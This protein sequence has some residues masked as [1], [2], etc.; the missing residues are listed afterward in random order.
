MRNGWIWIV[1]AAT[2]GVPALAIASEEPF[3][4]PLG[5]LGPDYCLSHAFG[6]SG[7][8]ET[9][10]GFSSICNQYKYHAFQWTAD[11]G[12]DPLG[13]ITGDLNSGA[14]AASLDGSV[15]VGEG[16]IPDGVE[17]FLWTAQDGMVGLGEL[18]GGEHYSTAWGVS[19]D[20]SVVVGQSAVA[21]GA[22]AFRWTPHEGMVALEMPDGVWAS[23]A[24]GVSADGLVIVGDM[25]N[26]DYSGE[27]FRWTE[28]EGMVGLGDLAGGSF[29]SRASAC[30]ADGW[31]VAGWGQSD[32]GWEAFRWTPDEGMV[33]LGFL[34][35][36]YSRAYA[37]S[38][39]GSVV[40]GEAIVED[41]DHAPFIWTPQ[42]GMRD[43]QEVLQSDLG[44]DLGDLVNLV[45]ANGI[46]AD[47]RTIVGWGFNRDG[48]SEGWVAYLGAS[49]RADFNGDGTVDSR[50]VVAYMNTWAQKSPLA[51]WNYDAFVDIR[52]FIAFLNAWTTGC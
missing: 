44:L 15:I 39:D 40:V 6:V 31:A 51:D 22:A 33:G 47:G 43:L 52:D 10:V 48:R 29:V 17:A 45:A 7:D 25:S 32:R 5:T 18:P 2:S 27:A 26:A 14:Q 20:G 35:S 16:Y 1:V 28:Q 19:A 34:Q 21:D 13:S 3:F 12:M 8:G 50:D 30:S 42:E 9:V 4:A 38:G 41:A 49:C 37:I 23:R 36:S 46:S 24:H 11:G